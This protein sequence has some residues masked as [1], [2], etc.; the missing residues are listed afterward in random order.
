[1]EKENSTNNTENTNNTNNIDNTGNSINPAEAAARALTESS[2][3]SDAENSGD[4]AANPNGSQGNIEGL[5]QG[6]NAATPGKKKWLLPAG[7]AAAVVVIGGGIIISQQKDPK[8][9]VIDAFK[10]IT[11]EGQLSPAEEVFGVEKLGELLCNGSV[12]TGMELSMS[13]SS[14]STLNEL[15]GAGASLD[16]KRDVDGKQ[17]N[18]DL[19]V[20]YGGGDLASAQLYVN[21]T[22][23]MAA[24]PEL[25]SKVFTLDYVND[26]EGQLLN[27]PYAKKMLEEQGIDIEKFAAYL[28]QHKDTLTDDDAILDLE[29]LWNRYKEESKAFDNLKAAMT[30]TKSDKKEFTIDGTSQKC[31]G[32]HVILPKDA[33]VS[34]VSTTKE[35][36]LNDDILKQDVVSYL[37]MASGASGIYAAA[38]SEEAVD[39]TKKQQ[40]LWAQAEEMFNNVE[41]AMENSAGDVTLDVYVRKDGK[42]AGFSYETEA[43]IEEKNVKFY[44]DV[45]FDGGY[46]MLANADGTLNIENEEG[47][48]MTFSIDKT[49]SYEA[50][51]DWNSK[52]IAAVEDD[53]DKYQFIMDADYQIANGSYEIKMDLQNN[54]VSQLSLSANG[55]VDELVKGERVSIAVDSLR[56]DT[57]MLDE[58]NTYIELTG[59]CYIKP[60]EEEITKPSGD[61]FDVL[62]SSEEDYANVVSEITGN[63]FAILM[64]LML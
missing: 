6:S 3:I 20:K 13:G 8:D 46:N 33:L 42:M 63:L 24:I 17:Q 57:L 61:A 32:Y 58:G 47:K 11:A 35:F 45:T 34:F 56:L 7:V 48:K 53:E 28:E 29:E 31:R 10:S 64:K 38:G 52:I 60:L 39:P 26:L 25:S 43:V 23:F 54:E 27:S 37:E 18:M 59:S 1:M 22:Q 44:G 19:A 36:F 9:T 15:S 55:T 16:L 62:A 50:G 5:E 30:V 41:K 21:D 40:E 51:K 12:Q 2:G 14:D 49:G 4:D